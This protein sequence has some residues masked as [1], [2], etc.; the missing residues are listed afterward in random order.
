MVELLKQHLQNNFPFLKD[1]KLL[2]TVSGGIDSVVMTYLFHQ[3]HY[4][5]TIAHCNFQLR[6]QESD[7]DEIFVKGIAEKLNK[8]IHHIK[9]NTKTYCKQQK[10]STQIGARELRYTWFNDLCKKHNYDYI[11]TAHHLSDVIETFFI[12]L[13]RGTGIDGLTGIPAL[14][15]NIVRPLLPFSRNQIETFAKEN[16]ITWREDQ[17]NAETKYIRNKIRHKIVPELYNLHPKF[18]E[19]FKKTIV[20]LHQSK[21]FIH[22]KIKELKKTLF[23]PK[24]NTLIILKSNLNNLSNFEIYELFQPYGFSS[25]LEIQKLLQTQTGK[26]INSETHSLLNNREHLVLH[27]KQ[28]QTTENQYY[29]YNIYNVKHLPIPLVFSNEEKEL[30]KNTIAIDLKKNPLP[31]ILRKRKDGDLFSPIGMSGKKKVSKFL[32]DEKLSKIE[33][34]NTWLLCNHQNNILWIVGYR[35]DNSL[36]QTVALK[37]NLIYVSKK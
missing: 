20:H 28:T 17:S 8:N 32:K 5:I 30:N 34:D 26:E 12:N 29:I 4:N 7:W 24:N 27:T 35:A 11:L 23:V 10:V 33:K 16:N 37:E 6:A 13:S 18:E 25:V 3:L 14:N 1:K 9:F 22:L 19:N 21:E 2:V 36:V 31:L 15:K